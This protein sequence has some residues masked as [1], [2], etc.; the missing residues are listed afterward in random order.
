MLI[1]VVA[2]VEGAI[3]I[4]LAIVLQIWFVGAEGLV[5]PIPHVLAAMSLLNAFAI[6]RVLHAGSGQ[7]PERGLWLSGFGGALLLVLAADPIYAPFLFP[8]ADDFMELLKPVEDAIIMTGA[9]LLSAVLALSG[10]WGTVLLTRSGARG[11]RA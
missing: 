7:V 5:A 9:L 2:V 10:G 1:A 3:A 6:L 4:L 8:P 11:R